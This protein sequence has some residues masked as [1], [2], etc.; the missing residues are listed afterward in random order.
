MNASEF[1]KHIG[2]R[3]RSHLR[4]PAEVSEA[5]I[6]PTNVFLYDFIWRGYGAVTNDVKNHVLRFKQ[7][8]QKFV[9]MSENMDPG[10]P[11]MIVC[12]EKLKELFGCESISAMGI[13]ELLV[14]HHLFEQ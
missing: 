10:N 1:L 12:D 6:L 5:P 11:V 4:F 3:S 7:S 13:P 9:A 14:R 8:V 2:L